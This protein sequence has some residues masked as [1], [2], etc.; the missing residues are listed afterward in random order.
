MCQAHNYFFLQQT[1]FMC[2][3]HLCIS[4]RIVLLHVKKSYRSAAGCLQLTFSENRNFGFSFEDTALDL[5]TR[6]RLAE[7]QVR[8]I[9]AAT[10]GGSV[11]KE[12]ICKTGAAL[13]CN[14]K[15]VLCV[16]TKIVNCTLLWII[17]TEP[18]RTS[19]RCKCSFVPV[20]VLILSLSSVNHCMYLFFFLIGLPAWLQV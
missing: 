8:V 9:A 14:D 7:V 19:R 6:P 13:E 17:G 20:S 5:S 3:P 11:Q 2:S 10:N 15:R 1:N 4:E 18:R 12:A 16:G